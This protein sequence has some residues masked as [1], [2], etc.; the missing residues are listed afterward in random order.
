MAK[1]NRPVTIGPQTHVDFPKFGIRQVPAKVDT[2]ADSSSIWASNIKERGG[3]LSFTL[4]GPNSPYYTG[5]VITTKDYQIRSIK[6][7]FGQTE[8][9]YKAKVPTTIEGRTI[10]IRY[11]LANR[12]THAFP[13]LIGR[14]T[15]H[16]RFLVDVAELPDKRVKEILVFNERDK[17]EVGRFLERVGAKVGKV[18]FTYSDYSDL[19]VYINHNNLKIKLNGVGR[20]IASYDMVYFKS[21]LKRLDFA[22]V[23]ALYLKRYNVPV[24]NRAAMQHATNNKLKQYVVLKSLGLSVPKSIYIPPERL[25]KSYAKIAAHLGEPFILKDTKGKKGRDNHLIRN[26]SQ[27]QAA[28]KNKSSDEVDYIAQEYIKNNGD[29]RVIVLGKRVEMIFHRQSPSAASHINNTSAGG[30]A[31]LV[32]K[33][34]LPGYIQEM[35]IEAADSLN[36]DIAGVDVIQDEDNGAWYC[37]EVNSGPQLATGALVSEKADAMAVYIGRMI[38][39]F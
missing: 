23:I 17:E 38:E 26:E 33:P 28:I 32:D 27:F 15:L 19:T 5:E 14:R 3:K 39:K 12:A 13:V 10:T 1:V 16:G 24:I 8:F 29:Y 37:L 2:G 20:D 21:Y 25:A 9:R 30:V 4:F 34:R 18:K 35:C 31:T 7:S 22:H 6:N 36:I 11:S